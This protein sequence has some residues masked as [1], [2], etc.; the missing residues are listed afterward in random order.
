MD[1]ELFWP[2]KEIEEPA[3]GLALLSVKLER[4]K[5][6]LEEGRNPSIVIAAENS[7]P[8]QSVI[9]VIDMCERLGLSDIVLAIQRKSSNS[10]A[11][12]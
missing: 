10:D 12:Q 3:A 4:Y 9:T 8:Y 6:G 7:V 2:P 5:K 11:S 1:G